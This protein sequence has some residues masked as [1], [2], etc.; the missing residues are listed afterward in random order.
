M[1]DVTEDFVNALLS[2]IPCVTGDVANVLPS[3]T[4]DVAGDVVNDP[5]YHTVRELDAT[6]DV[7]NDQPSCTVIT[8][9]LWTKISKNELTQL[10]K[11]AAVGKEI[12]KRFTSNKQSK[13]TPLSWRLLG[14]AMM[15][16]P[17]FSLETA[18]CF[19]A[20]VI[21]SFLADIGLNSVLDNVPEVTLSAGTLKNVMIDESVD[22]IYLEKIHN[23]R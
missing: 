9:K 8:D 18:S 1:S 14:V 3:H 6:G 4:T 2:H 19:I 13:L 23:E 11:D 16:C 12:R 17:K 5:Q 10:R 22:T 7:L 20:L 15:H 21:A